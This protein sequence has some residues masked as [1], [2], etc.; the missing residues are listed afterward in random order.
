MSQTESLR[1]WAVFGFWAVGLGASL[2]FQ[3]TRP[4]PTQLK[5]IHSRVYA[6][7]LTL[8]GLGMAGAVQWLEDSSRGASEAKK[9]T[10]VS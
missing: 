7:A 4:I 9:A 6:Q 5:I 3:W 2:A 8:A 1:A 10:G